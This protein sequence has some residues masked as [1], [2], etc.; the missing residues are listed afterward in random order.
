[1]RQDRPAGADQPGDAEHLARV[2]LEAD[3]AHAVAGGQAFD[4]EDRAARS[5]A[6]AL[7]G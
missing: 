4:L 6:P 3:V 7:A 1:M 5:T 2:E